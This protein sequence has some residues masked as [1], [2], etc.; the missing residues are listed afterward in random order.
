MPIVGTI[1]R[2]LQKHGIRLIR[3]QEHLDLLTN[4]RLA[5]TRL[6]WVDTDEFPEIGAYIRS[7]VK[8]NNMVS[9]LQQDFVAQFIHSLTSDKPGYFV[10][11]GASDGI[12]FSNTFVLEKEY[13]WTGILAEPARIWKNDLEKNRQCQIDLRCV[14]HESGDQIE[15][16]ETLSAE[17]STINH[18]SNSDLHR[19]NRLS[20]KRYSVETISLKDL[21]DSHGAPSTISYLSIDTEGSEFRILEHF[22]F[23][24]YIFNFISVEHNYGINRNIMKSLL[25]ANGYSQILQ[26]YSE[27]D[28]WFVHYSVLPKLKKEYVI[29]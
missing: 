29:V 20:G 24:D 7:Q 15:F 12:V 21:L 4:L 1:Q 6:K 8:L 27:F 11:F 14:W 10:E 5:Q 23:S 26:K 19:D 2:Y 18:F 9:Q 3:N 22:N 16:K 17:Y 25:E 13:F 28:D